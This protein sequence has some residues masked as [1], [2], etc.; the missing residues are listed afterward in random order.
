MVASVNGGER[1][2]CKDRH[3]RFISVIQLI[4]M[5]QG[6]NPRVGSSDRCKE[7][8]EDKVTTGMFTF[9]S[10]R[11]GCVSLLSDGARILK[12]C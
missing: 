4:M 5:V 7:A 9:F 8:V 11:T 12:R 3:S 1:R 10:S 6:E 2:G